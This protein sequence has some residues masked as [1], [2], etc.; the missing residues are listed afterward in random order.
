MQNL[1]SFRVASRYGR[2]EKLALTYQSNTLLIFARV[3]SFQNLQR[4]LQRK[5]STVFPHLSWHNKL[6]NRKSLFSPFL[7][8]R[9]IQMLLT[10]INQRNMIQHQHQS[11]SF[12]VSRKRSLK[13]YMGGYDL[14]LGERPRGRWRGSFAHGAQVA[15]N[16]NTNSRQKR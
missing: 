8:R 15:I 2:E 6:Y 12:S 11:G 10:L 1:A 4:F 16:K 14:G 3:A 9:R 5:L 7:Q 13:R